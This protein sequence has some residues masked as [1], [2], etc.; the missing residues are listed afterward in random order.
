VSVTNTG[1]DTFGGK[2]KVVDFPPPGVKMA[3]EDSLVDA[4]KWTCDAATRICRTNGNVVLSKF[5]NIHVAWVHLS[6]DDKDAK[7]LNCTVTNVARI[8]DPKGAPKN[9]K[10]ADDQQS[11]WHGLPA[12]LCERSGDSRPCPPGFQWA[13]DRCGPVIVPPPPPPPVCPPGTVGTHPNCRKP[14]VVEPVCPPGMIGRPP[15]CRRIEPPKCPPGMVGRPPNCR[16]IGPPKCPP[17]MVGRPPNCRRIGPP[18][19]PHG[20]VGRPPYCRPFSLRPVRP[21]IRGRLLQRRAQ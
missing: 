1:P 21:G 18:K 13:G 11:A 12:E 5:Q 20:M 16:R 9:T 19:C 7:A 8:F 3:F 6:G 10:P 15:Y 14:V 17:G 2:I 4:G